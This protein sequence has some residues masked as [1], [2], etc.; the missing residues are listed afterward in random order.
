M[1]QLRVCMLQI[2]RAVTKNYCSQINKYFYKITHQVNEVTFEGSSY[3]NI[4]NQY[5]KDGEMLTKNHFEPDRVGWVE[6]EW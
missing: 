4:P 2:P 6:N 1:Q 3:Q 5:V